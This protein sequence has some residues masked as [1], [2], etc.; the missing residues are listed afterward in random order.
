LWL[1]R[2]R[3]G[4]ARTQSPG[5]RLLCGAAVRRTGSLE[6]VH[7][8]LH[9]QNFE[10]LGSDP[11]SDHHSLRRLRSDLSRRRSSPD[12]RESL[13]VASGQWSVARWKGGVSLI[14]KRHNDLIAWHKA[15]DL[16]QAIYGA[17]SQF[18]KEEIYGLTS[19]IRRAAVSVPP[20]IAEGQ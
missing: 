20:N 12:A 14:L 11:A 9:R 5:R 13:A 15:M 16:V 7:R 10:G 18:P 6:A 1:H 17:T 4:V 2:H 8:H 19:Q 3:G